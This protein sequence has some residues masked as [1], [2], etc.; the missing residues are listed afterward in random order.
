[1]ND[2]ERQEARKIIRRGVMAGDWSTVLAFILDLDERIER[3]RNPLTP[4]SRGE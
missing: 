2:E 4:E 3:L 1:M